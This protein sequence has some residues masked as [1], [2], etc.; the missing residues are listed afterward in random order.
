MRFIAFIPAALVLALSLAA[1]AKPVLAPRARGCG[2]SITEEVQQRF[3]SDFRRL[4]TLAPAS[5]KNSGKA[6]P[7]TVPVN[8]HVVMKDNTRDGGNIPDDKVREQIAVINAAYNSTGVNFTLR[9]V[10]RVYKPTWFT[11]VAPANKHQDAMKKSLRKGGALDLNVYTVGFEN[12]DASGLLGYATFPTEYRSAPKDDGVVILHSSVPGGSTQNFNLG[13]T[14]THEVGHWLGLYHTFQGG[15][16]STGDEVADT[17]AEAG[18]ASGCPKT[19]D[20]CPNSPGVDPVE[21]FMDY[22]DDA[23]MNQ[24]TPGQ[25]ARIRSHLTAYRLPGAVGAPPPPAAESTTADAPAP[26]VPT[27]E[28]PTPSPAS[29]AP[30]PSSSVEPAT[31]PPVQPETPP[32]E[33]KPEQRRWWKW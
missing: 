32:A 21:N 10:N 9:K 26:E 28:V 4:R 5:F 19:R 16:G 15:C 29:E 24:F 3:E 25:G 18:P 14:L 13:H 20:S 30:A 27:P 23:C 7:V 8:F 1:D 12:E 6:G 11:G 17:P 33:P 22:S 31:V 2:S